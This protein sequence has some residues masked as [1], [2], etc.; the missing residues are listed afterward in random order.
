[1]APA[2]Y[3][4]VTAG[5]WVLVDTRMY[6]DHSFGI[7]RVLQTDYWDEEWVVQVLYDDHRLG[8]GA[9]WHYRYELEPCEPTDEEVM[10][11]TIAYLV[12]T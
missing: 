4:V 12:R 8:W 2:D 10:Q 9:R 6:D 11:W 3:P 5:D 1:M 7:G